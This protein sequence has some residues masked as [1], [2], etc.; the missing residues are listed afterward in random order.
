M[1]KIS[2]SS[3]K[4]SVFEATS[5]EFRDKNS[6]SR[7]GGFDDHGRASLVS[8]D[9]EITFLWRIKSVEEMYT[10]LAVYHIEVDHSAPIVAEINR[11]I[12]DENSEELDKY[13]ASSLLLTL[14]KRHIGWLIAVDEILYQ[15]RLHLVSSLS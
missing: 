12:L 15:P 5:V 6:I 4:E 14:I 2:Y 10:D 1:D 7:F 3:L 8:G 11:V 13:A 9:V